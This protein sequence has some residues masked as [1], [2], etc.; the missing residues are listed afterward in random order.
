MCKHQEYVVV[1]YSEKWKCLS[2]GFK[3]GRRQLQH[4]DWVLSP[5]WQLLW[6]W[7]DQGSSG[8]AQT[9]HKNT[10]MYISSDAM[11]GAAGLVCKSFVPG[12]EAPLHYSPSLSTNRIPLHSTMCEEKPPSAA[13]ASSG[14]SCC[15][16]M[17]PT[18]VSPPA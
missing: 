16:G 15:S 5:F 14:F 3:L 17:M 8:Q 1:Q 10:L 18:C 13:C 6:C 9:N 7:C 11:S 12:M 4:M 2:K